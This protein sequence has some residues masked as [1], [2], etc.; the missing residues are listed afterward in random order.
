M[1]K[2]WLKLYLVDTEILVK[3]YYIIIPIMNKKSF[4]DIIENDSDEIFELQ[5]KY[6]RDFGNNIWKSDE[7]K[8]QSRIE[9][10]KEMFF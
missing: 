6:I 3:K 4:R 2:N 5:N 1:Q 9:F 7:L 8:F 10:L